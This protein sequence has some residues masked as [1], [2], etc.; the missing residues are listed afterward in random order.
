MNTEQTNAYAAL[1][2]QN[3]VASPIETKQSDNL[4]VLNKKR[5]TYKVLSGNKVVPETIQIAKEN[6]D[7]E[8]RAVFEQYDS[9]GNPTLMSLTGGVKI[10]YL[11]N[12]QNQ[13][14]AK[15]ENFTGTL[16]AN[17]NSIGDITAFRNQFPNAM[18]S[19]FEY[20]PITNLLVRMYDPNGKKMTY[21]YD[22]LHRLKLIKDNDNN[23][24]K[25]FD[26]NFKN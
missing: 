11:Y 25:E 19:V 23:V 21:E 17:T 24:I 4:G 15:I 14:I 12:T 22:A 1:L 26:Q 18:V 8:E 10:K 16:D 2:A 7:L 3:N 20:D 5:T 6:F 9:K 13:V